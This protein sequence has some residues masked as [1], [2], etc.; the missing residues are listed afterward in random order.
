MTMFPQIAV[1]GAFFT[2]SA[3]STVRQLRALIVTYLI[4]TLPFT[5]WVLTSFFQALP[6]DLEEAAYVDGATPLQTIYKVMLPLVAPGLV[7]TGLLAFIARL[8]RVPVRALVHPDAGSVHG[9]AGDRELRRRERVRDPV[10]PD[11]G[12]DR[13]RDRA[14]DRVDA[15][16]PA[17]D[18][19]GPDRGRGQGLDLGFARLGGE[20]VEPARVDRELLLAGLAMCVR[21]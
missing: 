3:A 18:P 9:A 14:A 8:E 15:D 2:R 10:G 21:G 5:V 1:L 7:T 6:K 11:H 17:A 13:R 16:L 19:R 20:E 12:S 4:F